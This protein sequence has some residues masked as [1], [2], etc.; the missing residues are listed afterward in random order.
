MKLVAI[1]AHPDD[2]ELGCAALIKKVTELQLAEVY[3]IVL[4]DDGKAKTRRRE[5]LNG[6]RSMGV[7]KR[8]VLFAGMRDG[9]VRVS[10]RS[11]ERLR[12]MASEWEIA[13]DV[14][15]THTE[16]DSH[17]DHVEASRIAHAAF[18]QCAFLHF[19]IHLSAELDRFE[20]RLFIDLAQDSLESKA[21]AIAC[22]GSQ[23]NRLK[24]V[25]LTIHEQILGHL[26]GLKRVEAFEVRLPGQDHSPAKELLAL[27]DS[28]FHRFWLPIMPA[29]P[30]T[31]FHE[32]YS[33]PG[34]A[35]DWPTGHENVGREALRQAFNDRWL[36]RSPLRERASDEADVMA[37]LNGD[38]IVL[39]GGAVG[40]IAVR[41]IYN[42]MRGTV[43]AIDYDVPRTEPAYLLN[44]ETGVRHYPRFGGSNS[45]QLDYGV[46]SRVTNPFSP[47]RKIVCAAG[48]TGF[49]TRAALELLAE[50]SPAGLV[51]RHFNS[52]KDTQMAFAVESEGEHIKV[53]DVHYGR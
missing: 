12:N 3:L 10:A 47:K 14:I 4:T 44:R 30:L 38:S 21:A 37:S 48:A 41:N 52:A 40:N 27:S 6:A 8:R 46:L 18:R 45:V 39:V 34:A 50:A 2:I 49:A 33:Q 24:G 1:G 16:A 20:P 19:S 17:N 35:I 7:P 9:Q 53:L 11:V 42:R 32:G 22:H 26:A 15:I 5:A 29:E 13:P 36:P 31:I 28:P 25:D 23:E 51:A 43:W